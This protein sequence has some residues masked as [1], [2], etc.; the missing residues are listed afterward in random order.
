[1]PFRGNMSWSWRKILQLRPLVRNFIWY[2]LGDGSKA[3][4]WF[5]SWC[6]LSPLANIV[7]SRDV[8]RA[9]FCPTTT[10]RDIIT[11]NGW[12]WPSDWVGL[13]A[14]LFLMDAMLWKWVVGERLSIWKLGFHNPMYDLVIGSLVVLMTLLCAWLFVSAWVYSNSFLMVF[15]FLAAVS[16]GLFSFYFVM[17]KVTANIDDSLVGSTIEGSLT[18]HN[19]QGSQAAGNRDNIAQRSSNKDGG[20]NTESSLLANAPILKSILKRAARNVPGKTTNPS[21]LNVDVE[22]SNI[23]GGKGTTDD[24][25]ST[26]DAGFIGNIAAKV[27]S[28][29]G[30]IV[31]RDG[32]LLKPCRMVTFADQVDDVSN[33]Q[34]KGDEAAQGMLAD[35][36]TRGKLSQAGHVPRVSFYS[37]TN[38][39]SHV[40]VERGNAKDVVDYGRGDVGDL[41]LERGFGRV[42]VL[43]DVY[44]LYAA[45]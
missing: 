6:S 29:D 10:V 22:C 45:E 34:L 15:F 5:D 36:A 11:P 42:E 1:M 26:L 43:C 44:A 8:H 7:S 17:E 32:K 39:Q 31:G 20:I 28:V 12:A 21:K 38:Q 27:K 14:G 3:L 23:D 24:T 19:V 2:K 18:G 41:L 4:A 13:G 9:G 37:N 25:N 16:I 35:D 33:E 40:N 30:K